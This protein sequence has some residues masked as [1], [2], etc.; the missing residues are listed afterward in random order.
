MNSVPFFLYYM[1]NRWLAILVDTMVVMVIGITCLITILTVDHRS[2]SEAG[3]ALSFA[4]QVNIVLI[5]V[6]S[7]H[8]LQHKFLM[9]FM[10]AKFMIVVISC[11]KCL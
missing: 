4:I 8:S 10:Y 11:K 1:G 9:S 3:L 2:S 7:V 6:T 5:L